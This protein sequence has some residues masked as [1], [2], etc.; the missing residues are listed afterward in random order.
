MNNIVDAE[1]QAWIEKEKAASKLSSIVV[2]L[3]Y[4]KSVELVLFRKKLFD[5]G[6]ELILND[7]L[8]ARQI[9][10]KELNIH[11]SLQI[12]EVINTLD[13]APSRIDI[14]RLGDEWLDLKNRGEC[15]DK[16]SDF[17]KKQ[18]KKHIGKD[19]LKL[20]G[21]DV[22]LFGFGRIGRIAARLLIEKTGKGQQLRLKAIVVREKIDE[23]QIQKRAELLRNDSVF[24]PFRGTVIEDYE[25]KALII[26]GQRVYLLSSTNEEGLDFSKYGIEKALLIDN[27]GAWRDEKGLGRHLE[28]PGIEKVLL[29]A[30]GKGNIPNVV[31]GINHKDF[32]V[33][34]KIFSAASCTTNAIV[35]P[36]KVIDDH[37]GIAFGHIESI[38]SYTND[39]NL[40]DNFHSKYRRGRAAPLNLVIT[41]TGA[42][43][44]VA[45][46]LPQLKNKLTGNAVRIPTPN[47]SL[48]ILNLILKKGTSKEEVNGLLKHVSL[49]GDLIQQ[50]DF[51]VSKELVSSDIIR[52]NHTSIIDGAATIVHDNNPAYL[53]LYVWYDNEWGYTEQ[54][55][56]YS[57]YL[58]GVDR[59]IYY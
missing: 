45:K 24:G 26:N 46:A 48:A 41:E 34:G 32:P 43:T 27:T 25:N 11:D 6:I 4:N 18:L 5:K 52:N 57:K 38:H 58:A 2:D 3:W 55:I 42:G 56:R 17:I 54:V 7:H 9:I 20:Q 21:K 53:V 28:I 47:G 16:C 51:S 33:D 36:L 10:K 19:K 59:L 50:I 13:L 22:V 39:Q 37:F 35:P 49:H 40:L 8:A 44:A 12:A 29:T 31:Y 14:G 15:P 30:P 1:L 23:E